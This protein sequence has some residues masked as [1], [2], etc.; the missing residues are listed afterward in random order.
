PIFYPVLNFDYA[1]Q[2]AGKWNPK[3]ERSGYAGFVTAFDVEKTY[4]DQFEVHT[5]GASIHQELWIPAEALNEFNAHIIGRIQV[6]EAFYGDR[7]QGV[8]H[9]CH[10]MKAKAQMIA[11]FKLQN[12][13]AFHRAIHQKRNALIANFKFWML[14]VSLHDISEND[15][16]ETQKSDF[17]C[18][19]A[20]AWKTILPDFH[21]PGSELLDNA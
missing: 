17:L 13:E 15:F 2:I 6:R 4:V 5:V 8:I 21:L 14:H 12:S 7:Y 11:L 20:A 18:D 3:D 16:S 1:A 10:D 9:P 19:V